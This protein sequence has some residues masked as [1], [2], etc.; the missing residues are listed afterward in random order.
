MDVCLLLLCCENFKY[1]SKK[2]R[3][4]IPFLVSEIPF[5]VK[6]KSLHKKG[7]AERTTSFCKY[8]YQKHK[9]FLWA[10]RLFS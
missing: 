6:T 2:A 9:L 1:S 3:F 4:Q 7:S 8:N 5:G 10:S